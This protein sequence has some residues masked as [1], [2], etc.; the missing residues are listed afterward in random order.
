MIPAKRDGF[1]FSLIIIIIIILSILNL[2]ICFRFQMRSYSWLGLLV[3]E[4]KFKISAL[5]FTKKIKLI[6]FATN[7]LFSKAIVSILC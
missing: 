4:M 6:N 7:I 3:S 2:E 1:F 5:R